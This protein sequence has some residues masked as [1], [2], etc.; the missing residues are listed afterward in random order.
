MHILKQKH[1]D[2]YFH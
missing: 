2:N 1:K